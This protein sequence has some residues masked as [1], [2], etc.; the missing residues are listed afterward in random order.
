MMALH[1]SFE[2][3]TRVQNKVEAIRH[4]HRVRCAR[5]DGAGVVRRSIAGHDFNARVLLEPGSS[6]VGGSV[7]KEVNNP[8]ALAVREDGAENLALSEGKVIDPENA[9][10]RARRSGGS[11]STPEQGIATCPDRTPHTLSCA[12]FTAEGQREVAKFRIEPNRPLCG[13]RNQIG[14]ALSKRDS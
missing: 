5:T 7:G 13:H 10:C 4:L 3:L 1:H 2:C 12:R 14:Q 9:G 6:S 8:V 11:V